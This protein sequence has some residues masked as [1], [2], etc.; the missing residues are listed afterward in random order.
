MRSVLLVA[1]FLAGSVAQAAA[2]KATLITPQGDPRLERSRVERTYLGH[3][4]GPATDAPVTDLQTLEKRHIL[5]VL[6]TFGIERAILV[7]SMVLVLV[8]EVL[9]SAVEAVVDRWGV[10]HH[11]L[12]GRAKDMGSAAVFLADLNVIACWGFILLP[13]YL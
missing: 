2:L 12:A 5:A 13:R 9:N 6:D 4:G 7:G 8:V 1:A 10:E 11:E 3:P